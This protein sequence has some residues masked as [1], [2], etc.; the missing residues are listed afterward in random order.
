MRGM[1]R[2]KLYIYEGR[3][4]RKIEYISEENKSTIEERKL[5]RRGGRHLK[6]KEKKG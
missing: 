4:R 3:R 1:V 6:E 5:D 2:K